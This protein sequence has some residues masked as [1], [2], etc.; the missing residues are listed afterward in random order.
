[1]RPCALPPVLAAALLVLLSPGRLRPQEEEAA[2]AEPL[3]APVPAGLGPG[4][5]GRDPR[6]EIDPGFRLHPEA[7]S[8]TAAETD[9]LYFF[10]CAVTISSTIAIFVL[11]FYF[12][13]HFRRR[14]AEPPAARHTHYG[15]E[16]F[17]I[18]VPLLIVLFIF[19]WGARIYFFIYA[20]PVDAID[21]HIVGKQWMWKVQH[22]NGAREINELHVPLNEP[23]RLILGSQDVIHSFFIPA[24]RIK[25]DAVPGRF[26]I[27]WFQATQ[28]GV[29]R[30]FCAEYCGTDHSGMIGRVIVLEPE[31]YQAWL[32]GMPVAESPVEAGARLFSSLGCAS[33]HGV[34]APS[35]AGLYRSEVRL[36]DQRTVIADEHYIRESILDSTAKI[37]AGY[38]PIMPSFR[39]QL[40]EEQL[41][42]LVSYIK[43]LRDPLQFRKEE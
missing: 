27:A 34:R 10:L 9:A 23:V 29:F 24:F 33:C 4:S 13:V 8:T 2:Q 36:A 43:S 41:I 11:I 42:A 19:F 28:L 20:A 32:A 37:V 21:I 7:A 17:W 26:T 15:L 30:L 25:Q 22:P 39:G 5:L 14:S 18:V 40:T 35:L 38:P 12:S 16:V 1:M 3:R 6:P 31:K